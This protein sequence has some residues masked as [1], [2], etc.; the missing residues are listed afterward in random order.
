MQQ[1][2]DLDNLKALIAAN[3]N[4]GKGLDRLLSAK[5]NAMLNPEPCVDLPGNRGDW[6]EYNVGPPG[7]LSALLLLKNPLYSAASPALRS[8]MQLE[9]RTSVG[10]QIDRECRGGTTKMVRNRKKIHEWIGTDPSLLSED[11][12]TEL[13]DALMTIFGIQTVILKESE[14][15]RVDISFAPARVDL[16]HADRP[17][18]FVEKSLSKVWV[19]NKPRLHMRIYTW[20]SAK[21][22][23]GAAIEWPVAEGTKATLIEYLEPLRSWKPEYAK[24]LK[25]ELA[26]MAGRAAAVEMLGRWE[27]D[28]GVLLEDF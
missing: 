10:E 21:E 6:T 16:W 1:I 27:E 20:L 15:N 8:Q 12:R 18:Y 7:A 19:Y 3:P 14:G 26:E 25:D 4:R 22:L 11:S 5:E 24:K 17:V 13:W 2:N 23:S 9:A 28:G